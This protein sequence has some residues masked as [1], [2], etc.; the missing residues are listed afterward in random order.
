MT[1][2]QFDSFGEFALTVVVTSPPWYE[3]CYVVRHKDSGEIVIVDPGGDAD[4]ILEVVR[5]MNGTPKAIWLTH[6]HPDHLGAARALEL[7]LGI[8]TVAHAD[9][10]SVI[11]RSSDLNKSFTGQAQEG[12]GNVTYFSGEANLELG[13]KAIRVVHTPGHTPG[14]ICFDFGDFALTGDTLFRHGVG[15]TDLPGGSEQKLWESIP[16]FLG[17]L[18]DDCQL[19]SG[20]GPEWPAGEARRWWR[21]MS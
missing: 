20:H 3:N 18:P 19:F 4:R 15:R 13:G 2:Q 6:G 14:G 8:P 9:E 5:A 12:P 17:L 7:E 1:A 21:M 11:A 16:R 10:A